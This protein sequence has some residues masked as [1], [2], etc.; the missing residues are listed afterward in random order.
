[1]GVVMRPRRAPSPACE[2][3]K[4]EWHRRN[5]D[6]RV[7]A[8]FSTVPATTRAMYINRLLPGPVEYTQCRSTMV[9]DEHRHWDHCLTFGRPHRRRMDRMGRRRPTIGSRRFSRLESGIF[10]EEGQVYIAGWTVA[11]F[12]DDDFGDA[13]ILS[14]LVINLIAVDE[15]DQVGVLLDGSRFT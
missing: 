6:Q 11:L 5:S 7:L 3:L 12:P 4:A 10:L 1:M 2:N 15:N 13:F 9:S 14:F 8:A